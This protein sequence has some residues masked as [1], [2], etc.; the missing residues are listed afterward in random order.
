MIDVI[1]IGGGPAGLMLASELRLHR[2]QVLELERHIEPARQVRAL[3]LRA[4][5]IEV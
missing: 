1:V 2:A 5:S 4:R 3:G